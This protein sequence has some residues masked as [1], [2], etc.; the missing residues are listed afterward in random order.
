MKQLK[1]WWLA[2]AAIWVAPYL[3][4]VAAGSMWLWEHGLVLYFLGICGALLMAG[5]GLARWLREKHHSAVQAT[6]EPS[7]TWPPAGNAAWEQVEAIA[8]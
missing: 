6:V 3:L 2:V 5:W 4:M 1:T 7:P 8:A